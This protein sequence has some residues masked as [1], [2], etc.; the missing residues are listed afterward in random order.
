MQNQLTAFEAF[1]GDEAGGLEVGPDRCGGELVSQI[2]ERIDGNFTSDLAFQLG[3]LLL[4]VVPERRFRDRNACRCIPDGL[5]AEELPRELDPIDLQSL[6][7]CVCV[8]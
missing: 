1:C 3:F 8:D 7:Q 5:Y 6:R 2:A 4:R